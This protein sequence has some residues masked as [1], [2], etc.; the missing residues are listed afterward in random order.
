MNS[1]KGV[2]MELN[3]CAFPTLAGIVCTDN[4]TEGFKDVEYALLVG[5]KPRGFNI[6]K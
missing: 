3:D 5:A 6:Y 1:L 4:Q 2:A